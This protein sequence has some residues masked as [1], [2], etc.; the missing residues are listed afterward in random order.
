MW[1]CD[2]GDET[3]RLNGA[4]S[5]EVAEIGARVD[6]DRSIIDMGDKGHVAW[7][8]LRLSSENGSWLAGKDGRDA[9]TAIC[10]SS[11]NGG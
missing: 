10:L 7:T 3:L 4:N 6:V 11:D 5:A 1:K 9:W 8:G 2:E